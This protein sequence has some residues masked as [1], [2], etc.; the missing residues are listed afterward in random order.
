MM[1]L[2]AGSQLH[3]ITIISM[4]GKDT[5]TR[6]TTCLIDQCCTGSG[7]IT[8][9]FAKILG[10]ESAPSTPREFSTANGML[11]TFTEVKIKGVKLP[12]LYKRRE[13]ELTL[14]IVPESVSINYRIVLGLETIKQINLD[15]SVRN[16]TIC[17]SNELSTP[18]VPQSFWS[19]ER[20]AK[21]IESSHKG[22]ND[23]RMVAK[24]RLTQIQMAVSQIQSYLQLSLS[25]M[26]MKSQT[27]QRSW[28][29]RRT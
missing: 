24:I 9:A 26:T 12:V 28:Q 16:E 29:R 20:M 13:F 23:S 18:M 10:F 21:L 4:P 15:T 14:Q 17:W 27:S 3:P 25:Q 19:K 1:T 2:Q 7:M 11:T 8:S 6:A 5:V 22:S